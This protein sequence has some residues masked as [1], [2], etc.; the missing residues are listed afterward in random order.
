MR[1]LFLSNNWDVS[2][3]VYRFLQRSEGSKNVMLWSKELDLRAFDEELRNIECIVSYNYRH[4]IR[5]DV[6]DAFQGIAINLHSSFLPWNRGAGPNLWSFVEDTKKGV[7]IHK[8]DAGVD[9][10]DIL[11]QR[12]CRFDE[13][14]ETFVS[15]Y[16][17]LHHEMRALF[18]DNWETLKYDRLYPEKQS[19]KGSWHNRKATL[20]F[21][22]RYGITWNENIAECKNRM[23]VPVYKATE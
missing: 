7:T 9:T 12:E 8:I 10:G 6:L 16:N 5:K 19:G 18:F 4:I 3:P 17:R 1:I 23:A 15:T 13:K 14:N 22:N 11:L 20:D 21:I 2:K